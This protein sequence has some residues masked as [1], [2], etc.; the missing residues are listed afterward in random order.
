MAYPCSRSC[1]TAGVVNLLDERLA[2]RCGTNENPATGRQWWPV[3]H[4][5]AVKTRPG[6]MSTATRTARLMTD[7]HRARPQAMTVRA[8]LWWPRH[9][10]TIG[11]V[12]KSADCGHETI[13]QASKYSANS[14][15][16]F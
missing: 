14:Y 6:G 7:K 4:A 9:P 10:R 3:H 16:A 12:D 11:A 1:A 5:A 13:H 2:H 15:R 8:A